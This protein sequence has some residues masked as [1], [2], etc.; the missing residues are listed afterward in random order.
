M[1]PIWRSIPICGAHRKDLWGAPKNPATRRAVRRMSAML[2][3]LAISLLACSTHPANVSQRHKNT[4]LAVGSYATTGQVLEAVKTAE[5]MQTLPD[6]VAATLQEP[7]DHGASGCFDRLDTHKPAVLE[8]HQPADDID[9]GECA[10]GD[11]GGTKL[12]VIFGD[13]RAWMFSAPLELIAAKAGWKLRVFSFGGCEVADLEYWSKEM[14]APNKDCDAFRSAAISEIRTLH[15]NLVITTSAGDHNLADG[16]VPTPAQLQNGW[17]STFHQLAQPGT[18]LAMIGP[19]PYWPN[20]DARCLAAHESEVQAC[21]IATEKV[22]AIEH[23]APQAAA[24]A[25]AGVV[26]ISPRPWVCADRCEPVIAGIRV[27]RESYHF[28][29][30]YATYL[31]GAL[32]ESLQPAMA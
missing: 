22:L 3:A 30:T 6:I 8:A 31:T 12:M 17:V 24:A 1:T 11:R 16:T 27:Y 14:N 26:F 23:E 7:D 5:Q 21:S 13:S 9:F 15:P 19:I 18:R 2:S 4:P 25:A 20:N 32:S 10:S 29:A 28:S